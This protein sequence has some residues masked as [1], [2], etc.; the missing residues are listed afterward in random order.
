MTTCLGKSC[1]FHLPRVPFINCCQFMYLVTSLLVLRAWSDCISFWSLLI[2]YFTAE[3]LNVI[4]R[5]T[6]IT[7]SCNAI[8]SKAS[9]IFSYH[10]NSH[11]IMQIIAC[12][13]ITTSKTGTKINCRWNGKEIKFESR[14]N[15]S[16]QNG[17]RK[18]RS[19]QKWEYPI[20]KTLEVHSKL[21]QTDG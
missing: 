16:R 8:P 3:I 15:G 4:K 17:S 19:R 2:F 11:T 21:R 7:K 5:A 18:N 13:T 1:S 10:R 12:V 6:L 20:Q 14:Q 9:R